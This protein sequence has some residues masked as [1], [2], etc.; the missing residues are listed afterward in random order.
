MSYT[1]FKKMEAKLA[2]R[3]GVTDPAALAATIAR[4]KYGAKAVAHASATGTS[5]KGK[6]HAA[7]SKFVK[8]HGDK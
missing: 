1:P 7:L 4:R 5:L 3:P 8:K 2:S 6:H